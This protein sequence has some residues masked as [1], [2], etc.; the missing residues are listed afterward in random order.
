MINRSL[1][2]GTT[3]NEEEQGKEYEQRSAMC[4]ADGFG[5]EERNITPAWESP[6]GEGARGARE[7]GLDD[8]LSFQAGEGGRGGGAQKVGGDQDTSTRREDIDREL[9][10]ETHGRGSTISIDPLSSLPDEIILSILTYLDISDLSSLIKV[11]PHSPTVN[12]TRTNLPHRP[13][14]ASVPSPSTLSCTTSACSGPK[15]SSPMPYLNAPLLKL[16]VLQDEYGCLEETLSLE[17]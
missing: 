8:V 11:D 5:D 9:G 17:S 7:G 13:P 3:A 12:Q 14:T 4:I 10:L 1:S 2:D 16:S 6:R 15:T